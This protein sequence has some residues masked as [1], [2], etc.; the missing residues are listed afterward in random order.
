MNNK[1]KI[2][3]SDFFEIDSNLLDNYGAF[4]VSL[5][6]DLPL[7]IDPFLL[8]NSKKQVYQELHQSILKYLM[9]LKQKS[10]TIEIS[11][12]QL[13]SWYMFPEIKQNWLGFSKKGNGGSGLGLDFAHALHSNLNNLFNNF[14]VGEVSKSS[15][16]EKL[17]IIK[18]GVGKDN[19][20]DF[21]TRLIHEYLLKFTQE[22]ALTHL[23]KKFIKNIRVSNV[24]FNYSTSSWESDLFSLPFYIDD[25]VLLTP[26]DMLTRDDTWINKADVFRNYYQV[27]GSID[28]DSLRSQIDNYFMEHISQNS[29]QG[30]R[31]EIIAKII[32]EF[33]LF[34][35]YFIK[36]KEDN[37]DLAE[38]SSLDKVKDSEK[39]YLELF[40]KLSQ[41][42]QDNTD[43]YTKT[44]DTYEESLKRL[45]FLKQVIEHNDGYKIFYHKGKP[46]T[47]EDDIQILYRLTWFATIV[48]VNREV[49]NGRGPVDFKISDGSKDSTI[50]EFKLASN[51]KLKKN[52][53]KQ[54]EV[55]MQAN[56]TTKHFKAIVFFT[57]QEED[58][59]RK[60]LN[61]LSL[62]DVPN[63]VLI[64]ARNDN[65]PSASTA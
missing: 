48:D 16:L 36:F 44:E 28:N 64:D 2:Y 52:L 54:V 39:I 15:H 33:P 41:L 45:I 32:M 62:H 12:G 47:K 23:D 5:V 59:V 34:I 49:N 37:G 29:K 13:K 6:N 14:G 8:F 57:Q 9:F 55:Y 4:D 65:K 1:V 7:F 31:N 40:K 30:E 42:L 26:I 61:E 17:C 35:D 63:I 18:S 21:T 38:Q 3:F 11:K 50:I 56:Q 53:E 51:S 22:F 46:M 20:S 24:R 43:F 27:V 58:K 60:I 25:Y 10:E 19:I